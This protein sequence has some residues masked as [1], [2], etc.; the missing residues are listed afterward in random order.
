VLAVYTISPNKN[1]MSMNFVRGTGWI[2]T[3]DNLDLQSSALPTELL[4]HSI[5]NKKTLN[6]EVQG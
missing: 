6:V 3:T 5:Q 1:I 4:F 2:R